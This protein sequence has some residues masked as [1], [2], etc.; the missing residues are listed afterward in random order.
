[1][2]V[3]RH[4]L[5]LNGLAEDED[6]GNLLSL[7]PEVL[8]LLRAVDPVEAVLAALCRARH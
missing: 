5:T 1:M 4:R 6:G 7:G 2:A 8:I 3:G